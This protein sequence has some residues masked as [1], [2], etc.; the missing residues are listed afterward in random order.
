MKSL[1]EQRLDLERR[2][3]MRCGGCRRRIGLGFE[4]VM[5]AVVEVKGAR[6]RL[7]APK[8]YACSREDCDYA[9]KCMRESNAVKQIE[10]SYL[11]ELRGER[12]PGAMNPE[13]EPPAVDGPPDLG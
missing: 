6:D 9:E 3:G 4:F 8:T 11:D 7:A 10:W 5:F 12:I 1:D 13:N 2:L